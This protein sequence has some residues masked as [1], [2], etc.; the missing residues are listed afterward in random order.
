[1]RKLAFLAPLGTVLAVAAGPALAD[2]ATVSVTIGPDLQE[3]TRDL[4]ERDVREQADRLAEVVRR[5]LAD[6]G[7][8][9]GARIDLVLTDLKPNRPTFEQMADRPGLDAMDAAGDLDRAAEAAV[10]AAVARAKEI[11]G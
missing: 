11:S 6:S 8:L 5:A 4:G 1:M 10:K 9:D 3:K 7:D 2:P